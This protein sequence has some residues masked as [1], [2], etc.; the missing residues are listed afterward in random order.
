MFAL[1]TT[2]STRKQSVLASTQKVTSTPKCFSVLQ[3]VDAVALGASES[4]TN[5]RRDEVAAAS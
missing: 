5:L 4:T 2:Q 1:E 3:A